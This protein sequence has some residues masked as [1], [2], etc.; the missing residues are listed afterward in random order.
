MSWPMNKIHLFVDSG[1]YSAVRL[2]QPINLEEYIDF[3]KD[4]VRRCPTA[5]YVNLDIIGKGTE[6]TGEESY[7]NWMKMKEAGLNPLPVYH[8]NADVKWL[9]K[10]LKRVDYIG[11]GAIANTVTQRRMWSLD[12]IW[13][14]YL[15]DKPTRLPAFKIHAM[16]VTS[17]PL[18]Q[19]YPWY[20]IDSTSWLQVGMYG[21]IFVPRLRNNQ[22]AYDAKPYQMFVS[23]SSPKIK[24]R[25]IHIANLTPHLRSVLDRYIA[26]NGFILGSSKVKDGEETVIE[27]GLAND[28][29]ARYHLNARFYARFVTS[30]PWP[31]VFKAGKPEGLFDGE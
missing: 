21:K 2:G 10:Y 4:L 6:D 27:S 25:G 29:Y 14:D 28:Y 23:T 20:S 5:Q 17:F 26:E 18:M 15:I 11:L 9:V 19:R 1:A 30:M 8:V 13:E 22:W 12:R 3:C 16:G 24:K 31:R 7:V